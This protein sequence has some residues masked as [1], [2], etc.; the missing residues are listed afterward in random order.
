M[1][2]N[3]APNVNDAISQA[4]EKIQRSSTLHRRVLLVECLKKWSKCDDSSTD[5]SSSD[6]WSTADGAN[7]ALAPGVGLEVSDAETSER[8]DTASALPS[9][10]DEVEPPCKRPRLDDFPGEW[11]SV[12]H[13]SGTLEPIPGTRGFAD[14]FSDEDNGN[15]HALRAAPS[16]DWLDIFREVLED[17]LLDTDLSFHHEI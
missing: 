6:E 9:V 8:P 14:D 17:P 4:H 15:A 11:Q 12:A 13:N 7:P 16:P 1:P 5:H 10:S 2:V 3:R